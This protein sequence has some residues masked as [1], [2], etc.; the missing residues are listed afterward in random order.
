[1]MDVCCANLPPFVVE[2]FEKMIIP[3][4][5]DGFAVSRSTA[6]EKQCVACGI[7]CNQAYKVKYIGEEYVIESRKPISMEAFKKLFEA[8]PVEVRRSGFTCAEDV[9]DGETYL[10]KWACGEVNTRYVLA[11]PRDG[12]AHFGQLAH[13]LDD[14]MRECTR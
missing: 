10:V 3:G 11:N 14:L 6:D 7:N 9:L 1:M 2:E 4:G 5:S 12:N 8:V 13:R